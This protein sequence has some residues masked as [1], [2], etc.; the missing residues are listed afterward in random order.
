MTQPPG[1]RLVAAARRLVGARFQS[2]GRNPSIGLDCVGVV[3]AAAK[4]VG[5]PLAAP[6]ANYCLSGDRSVADVEAGLAQAGLI[7]ADQPRLAGEVLLFAIP[8]G[9]PHLAIWT[10][11]TIVHAHAAL[12]R[13]VESTVSPDWPIASEWR[14]VEG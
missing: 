3:Y 5:F 12:L 4:A 2:Q 1:E 10:G 8:L 6:Q 11:S 13:V 7:R 14:L 9:G